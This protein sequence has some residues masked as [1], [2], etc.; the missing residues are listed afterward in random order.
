MSYSN[1]NEL[2]K[3]GFFDL[4]QQHSIGQLKHHLVTIEGWPVSTCQTVTEQ[5]VSNSN[6][7][8]Y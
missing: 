5:S 1:N 4:C 8:K 6:E 3:T 2:C 7:N